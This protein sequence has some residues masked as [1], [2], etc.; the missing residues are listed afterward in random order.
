MTGFFVVMCRREN[1]F[2]MGNTFMNAPAKAAK[3]VRRPSEAQRV[4]AE[5]T[6]TALINAACAQFGKVGYHATG[7]NDLVALASVT[8]GALYHH[9]ADKADLFETVFREVAQKLVSTAN[10]KVARLSGDT[11]GQLMESFPAYLRLVTTNPQVQRILLIDGPAVLGWKRWRDIQSEYVLSG[12]VVA[13]QM[14]MDQGII[15]KR[16]PEPLANLLQAALDD[17]ALSIAHAA[18]PQTVSIEAADALRCLMAGLRI[19]QHNS[20]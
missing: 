18:D 13:L 2:Y 4:S 7:T 17:A 14:L 12:V 19:D 5:A 11:W 16:A 10:S 15:A 9:F 6:R 8:R 20:P 1:G 3:R